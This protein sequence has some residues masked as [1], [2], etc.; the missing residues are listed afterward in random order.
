MQLV[1]VHVVS[2]SLYETSA[3]SLSHLPMPMLHVLVAHRITACM[4]RLHAFFFRILPH[5]FSRKRET[6]HSLLLVLW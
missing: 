6:A 3:V 5:G 1:K 4:L 2:K